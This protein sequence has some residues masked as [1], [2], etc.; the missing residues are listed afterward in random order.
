[1]RPEPPRSQPASGQ[2][3]TARPFQSTLQRPAWT[4]TEPAGRLEVA[5]TLRPEEVRRDPE[6]VGPPLTEE[7]EQ[8]VKE[9]LTR[10]RSEA[11]S[12][13]ESRPDRAPTADATP[14]KR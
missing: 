4:S 14:P 3:A 2:L 7:Q 13:S 6:V 11:V 1:M 10:Y 8:Q 9:I 5:M 12:G